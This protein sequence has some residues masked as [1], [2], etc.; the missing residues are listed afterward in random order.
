MCRFY[1]LLFISLFF[2]HDSNSQIKKKESLGING[3]S[4]FIYS[5][6]NRGY[7]IHQYIGQQSVINTFDRTSHSLRQGFLQPINPLLINHRFDTNLEAIVYPNPF[8]DQIQIKF[9]DPINRVL[10]VRIFD[11]R[12]RMIINREYDSEQELT[13]L[14]GEIA[15]GVYT[16]RVDNGNKFLESKL[17][18]R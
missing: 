4:A 17:I 8:V 2:I 9:I 18:K 15:T 11:M 3:L 10:V 6:N 7:F 5:D 12:G 16:L 1:I 13:I 14:I